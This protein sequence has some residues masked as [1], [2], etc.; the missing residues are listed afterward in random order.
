[1]RNITESK[2]TD[3]GPQMFVSEDPF[4]FLNI[5]EDPKTLSLCRLYLLI[6]ALLEIKTEI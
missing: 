3:K 4:T 6:F 5:N 1:M 2:L